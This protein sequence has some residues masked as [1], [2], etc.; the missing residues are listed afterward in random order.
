MSR[1]VRALRE[2][3]KRVRTHKKTYTE[4]SMEH[5]VPAPIGQQVHVV[6]RAAPVV[7]LPR[8]PALEGIARGQGA[9]GGDI[10]HGVLEARARLGAR[11][12]SPVLVL[13]GICRAKPPLLFDF[14]LDGRLL[15]RLCDR[16]QV[17]LRAGGEGHAEK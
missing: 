8:V 17:A 1:G 14:V 16:G 7:G 6:L 12:P 10:V 11:H 4:R 2:R 13:R 9:C 5:T 3:E 15:A